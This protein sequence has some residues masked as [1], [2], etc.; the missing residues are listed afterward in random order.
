MIGLNIDKHFYEDVLGISCIEKSLLGYLRYLNFPY[1]CLFYESYINATDVLNEFFNNKVPYIAYSGIKRLQNVASDMQLAQIMYY[2]KPFDEMLDIAHE[3]LG[4]EIPLLLR[5][6]SEKLP[7]AKATPWAEEHFILL[8]KMDGI[9]HLL[10]QYPLCEYRMSREELSDVYD[11]AVLIIS[12]NPD[13][14]KASYKEA[15]KKGI[16]S[17]T[18]SGECKF[19]YDING[20][21]IEHLRNAIGILKISR[22]QIMEWAQWINSYYNHV[23]FPETSITLLSQT[24][25]NLSVLYTAIEYYRFRKDSIQHVNDLLK[26]IIQDENSFINQNFIYEEN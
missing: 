21:D 26:I 10:N 20:D 9:F 7:N 24:V 14:N 5:V 8:Y 2:E 11:G 19:G 12:I 3:E 23:Y 15:I 13:F 6:K 16:T 18:K 22:S 17:I 1:Q 4:K 25:E